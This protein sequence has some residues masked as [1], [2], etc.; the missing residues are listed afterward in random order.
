VDA[1]LID[2]LIAVFKASTSSGKETLGTS[3]R[4]QAQHF[5]TGETGLGGLLSM[6]SDCAIIGY[7]AE[8][9]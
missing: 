2:D 3:R 1:C 6:Q 4:H 7:C 9:E 5:N 8:K